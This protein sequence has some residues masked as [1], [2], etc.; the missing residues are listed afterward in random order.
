MERWKGTYFK[1]LTHM[2]IEAGK[3]KIY[4]VVW[5]TGDPER[6]NAVYQVPSL[7]AAEFPLARRRSVYCFGI[8]LIGRGPST[9]R[10]VTGFIPHYYFKCC[11][12]PKT[13]IIKEL[14]R[15]VFDHI[16]RHHGLAKLTYKINNDAYSSI[17]PL[18]MRARRMYLPL[19]PGPSAWNILLYLHPDL[20]FFKNQYV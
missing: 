13:M 18:A 6:T 20:W 3:F 17:I 10:G 15:R 8:C 19:W 12:H 1:E 7:P 4:R 14:S 11:S 2:I 16:S 9:L 5:Q